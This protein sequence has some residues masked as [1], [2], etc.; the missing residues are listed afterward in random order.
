MTVW[1]ATA[2]D[3][4]FLMRT[5]VISGF[6]AQAFVLW[7]CFI[8]YLFRSGT[9]S[10]VPITAAFGS[11][12]AVGRVLLHANEQHATPRS[13][14]EYGSSAQEGTCHWLLA[15]GHLMLT[16]FALLAPVVL[17]IIESVLL[18]SES[19][20]AESFMLAGLDLVLVIFSLPFIVSF[21]CH[22]LPSM[23]QSAMSYHT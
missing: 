15:L 23:W 3:D 8:T 14:T 21:I 12:M 18:I 7:L 4:E 19:N 10:V 20:S 16:V 1:K 13:P 22:I 2:R 6:G 9:G 17:E 5:A 11:S